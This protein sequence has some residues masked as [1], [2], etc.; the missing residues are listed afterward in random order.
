[1]KRLY[2]NWANVTNM[3]MALHRIIKKRLNGIRKPL[4]Q[5]L[6]KLNINWVIVIIMD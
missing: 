5:N 1:M 2:L 3:G 6:T 4:I